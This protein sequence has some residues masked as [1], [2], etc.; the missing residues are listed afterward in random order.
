MRG[1]HGGNGNR[2]REA[3]RRGHLDN[4]HIR[5]TDD[6]HV[7]TKGLHGYSDMSGL[8]LV[9]TSAQWSGVT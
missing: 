1:D 8:G 7:H 2:W 5:H 9:G 4:R 3:G 6:T